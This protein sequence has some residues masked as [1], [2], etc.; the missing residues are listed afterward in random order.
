MSGAAASPINPA[1][2]PLIDEARQAQALAWAPYSRFSVGAA[3]EASD[4]RVFRGCNVENASFPAGLCAERGA[5][6][7]AVA[8]GARSFVRVVITSDAASP[9]PPCGVCRQALA[10][11][12]PSLEVVSVAPSGDTRCWSLADLLPFPFTTSSLAHA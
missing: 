6:A 7:A 11:F 9:A 10:E 2:T 8:Q 5:L 4:G 3:L 1:W 12:A